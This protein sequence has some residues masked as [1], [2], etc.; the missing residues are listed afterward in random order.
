MKSAATFVEV[1]MLCTVSSTATELSNTCVTIFF[2]ATKPA[3]YNK[4]QKDIYFY[5]ETFGSSIA[6]PIAHNDVFGCGRPVKYNC[7]DNGREQVGVKGV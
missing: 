4:I 6:T 5:S 1:T 3:H 7:V 2:G